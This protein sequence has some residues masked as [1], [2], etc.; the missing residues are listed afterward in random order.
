MIEQTHIG[1]IGGYTLELQGSKLQILSDYGCTISLLTLKNRKILDTNT[2]Y[3]DVVKQTMSKNIFLIPFPNRIADATYTFEN[4]TYTLEKNEAEKGNAIHGLLSKKKFALK[5]SEMG[6]DRLKVSFETNLA[7]NEFPGYPFDLHVEITFTLTLYGLD[8]S[9]KTQNQSSVNA[10]YGVGWHPY[11]MTGKPIDEGM[12]TIPAENELETKSEKPLIPTGK[13]HHNIFG[14]EARRV[15]NIA[16]DQCFTDFQKNEI[17]FEDITVWFDPTMK[18]CQV[19]TPPSRES[20]AIEPMSSAPDAFNNQMGI[21]V[22]H[23]HQEVEHRF[24]IR[25][26]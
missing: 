25:L 4:N 26:S 10:P 9:V 13:T 23:P 8:I 22:L 6:E 7:K 21:L 12:I 18:Y 2:Q 16:F 3:E 19:Y 1:N 11:I 15:S 5:D 20:I 24:G 17:L 14:T